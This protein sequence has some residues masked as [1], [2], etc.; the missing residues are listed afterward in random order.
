LLRAGDAGYHEARTIW[1]GM[2]DRHLVLI[3]R[4][5]GVA[6]VIHCV[7]AGTLAS[8]PPLS[9]SCTRLARCWPVWHSIRSSRPGWFLGSIATSP[10]RLLTHWPPAWS[11]LPSQ[12]ARHASH[13]DCRLL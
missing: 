7:V 5:A 2:I 6:D 13:G 3:D 8:S 12:M 1:N 11:V 4:C 10:G 9:T